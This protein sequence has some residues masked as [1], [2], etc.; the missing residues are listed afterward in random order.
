VNFFR[1]L[2]R[3]IVFRNVWIALC[4]VSM[5]EETR[6]FFGEP[7]TVDSL[8]IFIFFAT[9]FEY[10]LHSFGGKFNLL[11]PLVIFRYL[12]GSD[13]KPVLRVCVI[14]GFAGSVVYFF[15]LSIKVMTAMVALA[16]FTIAYTLPLIKRKQKFVRLRE[17]TYMKV[18]T[19]AFVWSF[20]T[21]IVPML[22]FTNAASWTEGIIIFLRRFLFIYAI[23]IPFEIRDVEREKLFGNISL[24]MIYGIKTI[25]II[26]MVFIAV[27]IALCAF[28]EQYFSFVLDKRLNIFL[29]LAL[30]GVAA[31]LLIVYA[32]NKRT[33]WYFKFTTDGTMILQFI[34]L[35][36]FNR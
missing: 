15:L 36:I 6:W 17:V 7:V 10:N 12:I 8:A 28:H 21:V 24:P 2:A 14:V 9:F 5:L 33:N 13:I 16:L 35:L 27:F 19:V 31:G 23:T 11:E 22:G 20:V 34:L 26:G 32:S 4:A 3:F 18:F 30:S 29:P 1:S 25:K